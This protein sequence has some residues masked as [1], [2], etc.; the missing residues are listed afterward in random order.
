MAD[1]INDVDKAA[2][3]IANE[4]RGHTTMVLTGAG[5][6]TDSGLPDYRGKGTTA[7]PSVHY[8]DYM[9][10][11]S[12][13]KWVWFRNQQTWKSGEY[14]QPNAGHIALARLQQAGYIN[15]I[16]TQNVD[17]LH[18]KAGATAVAELHGS[19]KR[20]K[21]TECGMW[22]PRSQI[23]QIARE[24]NPWVEE[25]YAPTNIE[26]P[27][28]TDQEVADAQNFIIPPCPNCGGLLKPGVIY[29]GEELP[30]DEMGKALAWAR[31]ADV[32]MVVGSSLVVGTGLWVLHEGRKRGTPAHVII[33]N[34]GPTKGDKRATVRFDGGA[35]EVLTR[36]ADILLDE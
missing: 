2:Q 21:C 9:E 13:Q 30:K 20:V 22:F 24:L 11:P 36:L 12:W 31:E 26:V 10:R 35:S 33:I 23:D 16:A 7:T 29:F 4:M 1:I 14:L 15:G 32:V 19:F 34:R 5:I 6:S 28:P 25:D 8:K 27:E 17:N 18:Q 3:D